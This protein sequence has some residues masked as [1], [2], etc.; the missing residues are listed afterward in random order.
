MTCIRPMPM[1]VAALFLLAISHQTQAKSP[2]T[3]TGAMV[4]AIS[5]QPAFCERAKRRPECRSQRK[6]RFDTHHFSLHGLWPQPASRSYCGVSESVVETDK[7]RRWRDLPALGLSREMQRALWQ[8]MPGAQSFL[9]RH[10]WIKHGTCY[11]DSPERYF[12]DSVALLEAINASSVRDLFADNIGR[13][14][15]NAQ[16]RNAFDEAFGR[17]AGLR[18]RVSCRRDGRREI[19]DEITIGLSGVIGDEPSMTRLIAASRPT[20]RGCP[21]G[22][23]D[24]VG[25]Q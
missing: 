14:L 2:Q 7:R 5:W 13:R 10:E 9:H 11:S 16:I 6:G 21:A 18:V 22:I 23:V 1:V 19:I 3:H 17:G 15:T 20:K 24:P 8:M 25:Y 4:L 12:H